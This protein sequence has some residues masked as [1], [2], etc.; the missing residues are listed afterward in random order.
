MQLYGGIICT[1]QPLIVNVTLWTF[2]PSLNT[3]ERLSLINNP[4]PL[5]PVSRVFVLW[6]VTTIRVLTPSVASCKLF[7]R[8]QIVT[9]N[10]GGYSWLQSSSRLAFS[11]YEVQES[12]E[13]SMCSHAIWPMR[14][15]WKIP[16]LVFGR[17]S[18][19]L[20]GTVSMA[21]D[22]PLQHL[23]V[24]LS[25]ISFID[26]CDKTVTWAHFWGQPHNDPV[27]S[28]QPGRVMTPVLT[29]IVLLQFKLTP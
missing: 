17:I 5:S 24:R 19:Q 22:A 25:P 18:P 23:S 10:T 3:S 16:V 15:N 12:K 27:S 9:G 29:R 14:R 26:D 20:Y 4:H 6:V 11:E 2:L 7:H 21:T 28:H 8:L 1:V 13:Y